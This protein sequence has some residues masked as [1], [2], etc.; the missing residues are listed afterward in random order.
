MS[1]LSLVVHLTLSDARQ[2]LFVGAKSNQKTPF[3]SL[4]WFGPVVGAP[5]AD[6]LKI[7]P[8]FFPE[9]VPAMYFSTRYFRD[10]RES[11]PRVRFLRLGKY[12]ALE[13][14]AS[15]AIV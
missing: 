1:R 14:G 5:S 15:L 9:I 4:A 12:V 11:I 7:R 13:S 6:N 2:L 10:K 3:C 8:E